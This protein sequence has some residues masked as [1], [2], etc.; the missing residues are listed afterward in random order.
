MLHGFQLPLTMSLTVDQLK[1]QGN[2]AFKQEDY[3]KAIHFYNEAIK[4]EKSAG[5]DRKTLA[6]LHSNIAQSYLKQDK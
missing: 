3:E 6:I 5:W 2:E 1:S 4:K